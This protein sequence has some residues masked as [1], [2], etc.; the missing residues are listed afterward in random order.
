MMLRLSDIAA[1]VTI[2]F[3]AYGLWQS[4]LRPAI[5]DVFVPPVISYASP[6]NNSN[7]EVFVIPVTIT[8]AGARATTVLSIALVVTDPDRNVSKRFYSANFGPWTLDRFQSGEIQPFEPIWIPGR[9][10]VANTV[11]C[12]QRRDR[13][14][15]CGESG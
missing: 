9:S 10:N 12:A 6:F 3:S 13:D 14:A 4:S 7:F 5:L 2:V 11:L 1:A 15:D 8:N